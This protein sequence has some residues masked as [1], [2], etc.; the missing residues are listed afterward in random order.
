[1]MKT[2][3]KILA[4]G[5]L[6]VVV[7]A[8]FFVFGHGNERGQATLK[9]NGGNV[10]VEYGRPMLKGRDVFAMIE[11]GAYWRM[12][13]DKATT[14]TTDVDLIT[15]ED[16]SIPPGTHTLLAHFIEKG[17]WTLVVAAGAARGTWEPQ[18]LMAEFPMT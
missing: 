11:P 13:A 16:Q 3:N 15:A 6:S 7:L 8:P 17:K 12:G 5:V 10:S 4:L 18:G 14:M 1:M 2:R 9:L